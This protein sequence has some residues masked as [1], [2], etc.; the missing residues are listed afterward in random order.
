MIPAGAPKIRPAQSGEAS[1][2]FIIV[3]SPISN[4][5]SDTLCAEIAADATKNPWQDIKAADGSFNLADGT[6]VTQTT[7]KYDLPA[8]VNI[9]GETTKASWTDEM[10][11]A[12]YQLEALNLNTTAGGLVP[13]KNGNT[14]YYMHGSWYGLENSRRTQGGDRA[15]VIYNKVKYLESQTT[16]KESQI[17]NFINQFKAASVTEGSE[18]DINIKE[19][20]TVGAATTSELLATISRRLT[21]GAIKS[22]DK[23]QPLSWHFQKDAYGNAIFV[24]TGENGEIVDGTTKLA[25]NDYASKANATHK[26]EYWFYVPASHTV[27]YT[28]S[29]CVADTG[30]GT[31]GSTGGTGNGGEA[32]TENPKTGVASYAVIG[33]LLVGAA[34]AYMYARKNNKFNRV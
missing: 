33:T 32:G 26:N 6:L 15:T 29:T 16:T 8:G 18:A 7:F 20:K 19:Q 12:N 23:W 24:I 27:T 5:P 14:T 30:G 11:K 3:P 2:T 9:V 25:N 17:N 4:P 34:S 31:G 21:P 13:Y 28:D 10:Y 22:V 1:L